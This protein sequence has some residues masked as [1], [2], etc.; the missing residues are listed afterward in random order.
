M[1]TILKEIKLTNI[2]INHLGVDDSVIIFDIKKCLDIYDLKLSNSMYKALSVYPFKKIDQHF[3]LY[4]KNI[5]YEMLSHLN[6]KKNGL[7][8]RFDSIGYKKG[9]WLLI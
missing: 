1:Q 2:I 9:I 3:K 5:T 8:T 7:Y 6:N 4:C